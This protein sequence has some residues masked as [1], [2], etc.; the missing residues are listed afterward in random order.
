M[1]LGMFKVCLVSA[2]ILLGIYLYDY[3]HNLKA[4]FWILYVGFGSLLMYRVWN[5]KILKNEQKP[6]KPN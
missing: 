5:K 1:E 4:L 2:G 6:D 3:F